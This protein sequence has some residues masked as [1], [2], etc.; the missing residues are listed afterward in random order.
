MSPGSVVETVRVVLT[1]WRKI[2]AGARFRVVK[3][4]DAR[5]ASKNPPRV[6]LQPLG[7]ELPRIA[8]G[9]DTRIALAPWELREVSEGGAAGAGAHT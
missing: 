2:P 9:Y 6:V 5:G 8:G 4:R 1:P 3:T 7:W